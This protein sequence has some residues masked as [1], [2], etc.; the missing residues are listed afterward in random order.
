MNKWKLYMYMYNIMP[1]ALRCKK[2]T[3]L[4]YINDHQDNSTHWNWNDSLQ[5]LQVKQ[6]VKSVM[7]NNFTNE[8]NSGSTGNWTRGRTNTIT[9]CKSVAQF[10]CTAWDMYWNHTSRN[11]LEIIQITHQLFKVMTCWPY[12]ACGTKNYGSQVVYPRC[13]VVVKSF[14]HFEW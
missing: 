12:W 2:K 10:K 6:I 4:E 11:G 1:K 5:Y 3:Q 13:Q 8:F 7:I 14:K 9:T